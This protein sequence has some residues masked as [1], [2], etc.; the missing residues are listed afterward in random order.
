MNERILKLE[1]VGRWLM[2]PKS[3]ALSKNDVW[4]KSDKETLDDA[5]YGSAAKMFSLLLNFAP[6]FIDDYVRVEKGIF[7]FVWHAN[8]EEIIRIINRSGFAKIEDEGETYLIKFNA[9]LIEN[10]F[11]FKISDL[12]TSINERKRETMNEDIQSLLKEAIHKAMDENPDVSISEDDV[13]I[14]LHDAWE[15]M[16]DNEEIK[17]T[18]D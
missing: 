1:D 7:S 10:T 2:M 13:R 8:R 3:V 15:D 11:E 14:A 6:Y 9:E 12:V 16:V 4:C 5:D 18:D 17:P